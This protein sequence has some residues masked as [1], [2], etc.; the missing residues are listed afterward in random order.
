LRGA[1]ITSKGDT[2]IKNKDISQT[3]AERQFELKPYLSCDLRFSIRIIIFE[4]LYEPYR[5]W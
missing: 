4:Q 1:N 2:E 5:R 3:D